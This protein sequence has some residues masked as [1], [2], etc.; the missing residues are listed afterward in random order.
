MKSLSDIYLF[1][2]W[3]VTFRLR[4]AS[5]SQESFL[6]LSLV[7]YITEALNFYNKKRKGEINHRVSC[8][9]GSYR[10][11]KT[12][13][14]NLPSSSGVFFFF[15]SRHSKQRTKSFFLTD[16]RISLTLLLDIM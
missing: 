4:T 10:I 6:V 15:F 2:M 7:I 13:N 8:L 1:P 14:P 16:I 3:I 5:L 12:R 11:K 9:C